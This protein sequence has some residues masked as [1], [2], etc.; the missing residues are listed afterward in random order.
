[1]Q[2]DSG[3]FISQMKYAKEILKKFGMEASNPVLNPMTPGVKLHKDN[4]GVTV[5][6]SL[7]KQLVGSMVYLTTTRPD[8][9]YTV[10][11][12]SRY[13]DKPTELHLM[14]TKRLLRYLQG[15]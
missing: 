12:V 11:M 15:T 4:E 5:N 8:I 7:F 6:N 14:K 13:M 3:I 9:M 10:S 2:L 1:M